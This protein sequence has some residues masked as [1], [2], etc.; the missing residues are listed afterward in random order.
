MNITSAQIHSYRLTIHNLNKKIPADRLLEAAGICGLQNS[1]PG[2]WETA[3]FNRLEGCTLNLL[4][5][6]LYQSKTLIQAW[7]YRGVP[8]VF[9]TAESDIFLS[10]LIASEG[11]QPWIYTRGITMALDFLQLSFD[12]L[13]ARTKEAAAYLDTNTIQ[14]KEA[15]D[16][17]LAEIMQSRLPEEKRVLWSAPSMYGTPD[18]QTVGGAA[19]SFNLR[20]C[21]Y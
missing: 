17:T 21:S 11:E 9:P 20:P 5:D 18:R 6:A 7:G 15:L 13:L 16:R 4:H 1:P 10:P 3:M 19:V 12:D 14:S 8:V 2:A